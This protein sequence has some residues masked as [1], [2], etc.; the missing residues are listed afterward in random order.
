LV[1]AAADEDC[2]RLGKGLQASGDVGRLADDG[3]LVEERPSADVAGDDDPGL[4]A[5]AGRELDIRMAE[6]RPRAATASV[7]SS[8]ARTARCASSSW[9]R[10]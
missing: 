2:A 4:N 8:P 6:I 5:D 7:S 9:A 1:G 3:F 10:G